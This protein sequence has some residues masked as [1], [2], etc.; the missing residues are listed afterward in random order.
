MTEAPSHHIPTIYIIL[1]G[2]TGARFGRFPLLHDEQ[3]S[4][5]V[6]P[7]GKSGVKV[8]LLPEQIKAGKSPGA[9]Y[10]CERPV[11]YTQTEDD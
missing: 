10:C 2:P 7:G 5:V 6:L 3:G 1:N 11:R 9:D 8:R 4:F